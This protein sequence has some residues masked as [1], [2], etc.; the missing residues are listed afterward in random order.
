MRW[1]LDT[2]AAMKLMVE[3][4]E[5]AALAAALDEVQP[6]LVSCLLLETEARRAAHRSTGLTQEHVTQLLDGVALY[7]APPSLFREAGLF[8]GAALRSLDALHLAAAVRLG[9][10]AVVTYDERMATSARGLGL[11][12]V[13]PG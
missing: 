13:A 6:D 9:A 7:E 10:D 5:S 2:S 8:P 12:V 3:E 11:A 1:Y 4:A